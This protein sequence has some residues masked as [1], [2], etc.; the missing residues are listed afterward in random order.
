MPVDFLTDEQERRYGRYAAEPSPEQLDKY[1]HFDSADRELIN[2]LGR[3]HF[4]VPEAVLRGQL[5]QLRDPDDPAEQG[6]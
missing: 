1:F 6:R 3:Y 4:A 5:R 2:L